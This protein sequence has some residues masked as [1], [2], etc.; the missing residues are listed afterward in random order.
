MGTQ[1]AMNMYDSI[2]HDEDRNPVGNNRE[3]SKQDGPSYQDYSTQNNMLALQHNEEDGLM[4]GGG[5]A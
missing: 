1:N 5:Q 3:E 2:E 4:I